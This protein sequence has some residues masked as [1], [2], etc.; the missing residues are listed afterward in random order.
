MHSEYI[1][2][3]LSTK[4]CL[5]PCDPMIPL[6][7]IS[8]W[9][10][11]ISFCFLHVDHVDSNLYDVFQDREARQAE[12]WNDLGLAVSAHLPLEGRK[13]CRMWTSRGCAPF[14]VK[15]ASWL[16]RLKRITFQRLPIARRCCRSSNFNSPIWVDQKL[17]KH[18]RNLHL[19]KLSYVPS[20]WS[21][22]FDT[23][24]ASHKVSFLQ[25]VC[26]RYACLIC[27]TC[28]VHLVGLQAQHISIC[29]FFQLFSM[30]LSLHCL[31]VHLELAFS[32]FIPDTR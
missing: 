11:F 10:S 21:P 1:V 32:F 8:I 5:C 28:Q 2:L 29:K 17:S 20:R 13:S 12:L 27:I 6:K 26:I 7:V 25:A 9:F 3:E 23:A 14:W 24:P 16:H 30:L 22:V 31:A 4:N 19:Q 18:S 15:S